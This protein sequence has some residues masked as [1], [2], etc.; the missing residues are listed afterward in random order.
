[1]S[2]IIQAPYPLMQSTLLMPSPREG[3]QRNLAASV[4]T[5]R[6]MN[7]TLYT[8]VKN[9]RNRK[10][11]QWDFVGTKDKA[12]EAIEF[13]KLYSGGPVRATDHNG[14][15]HIGYITIN[16]MEVDG[17]GRAGGFPSNEVYRWTISIEEK[18]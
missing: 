11:L 2:F 7:G 5:M 18:V 15:N 10:V 3:N 13:V 9:K 17:Q 12:R 8:F 16:P 1:M 4:Q 6:S 14:T